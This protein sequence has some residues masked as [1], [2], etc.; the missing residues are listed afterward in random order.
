[1]FIALDNA[2][3]DL[4]NEIHERV[5]A[6]DDGKPQ[7]RIEEFENYQPDGPFHIVDSLPMSPPEGMST[8]LKR[9]VSLHLA[10]L[11]ARVF[12]DTLTEDDPTFAGKLPD[13]DAKVRLAIVTAKNG[14]SRAEYFKSF[15]VNYIGRTL[16]SPRNV[17]VL[18]N[19]KGNPTH[20]PEDDEALQNLYTSL[21]NDWWGSC[22]FV[23]TG[24]VDKLEAFFSEFPE[25]VPLAYTTG[26]FAKLKYCGV[27]YATIG[28]PSADPSYGI[29]VREIA[30]RFSYNQSLK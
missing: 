10:T 7:L 19:K 25:I 18:D 13:N 20:S 3:E 21:P 11:G 6:L 12:S 14:Q 16:L 24:N 26:A 5:N 9:W 27:E 8:P 23:S 30:N 4:L 2:S 29:T 22:G 28:V 17:I 15:G 1:M